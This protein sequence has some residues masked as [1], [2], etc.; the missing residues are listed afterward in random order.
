MKW[1]TM[2]ITLFLH[3]VIQ[4]I[5]EKETLPN[6]FYEF[7][8]TLI[9]KQDKDIARKENWRPWPLMNIVAK[10]INKILKNQILQFIKE[11]THHNQ[12]G[13]ISGMQIWFTTLT[14]KRKNSDYLNRCRK[15]T[16]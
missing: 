15:S 3:D 12:V 13:L 2:K 4:K 11:I 6:L 10:T 14:N 16:E 1:L 7:N 5:E 8:I 9:L